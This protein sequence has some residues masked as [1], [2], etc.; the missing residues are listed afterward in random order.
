MTFATSGHAR[1]ARQ[2]WFVEGLRRVLLAR[3]LEE[4]G[5]GEVPR[6]VLHMADPGAPRPFRR[7]AQATF[8]VGMVEGPPPEGP[9]LPAL[10]PLLVRTLS[11]MLLYLTDGAGTPRAYVVTLEQ[12][13]FTIEDADEAAFFAQVYDR[14]YPLA[15]AQLVIN[16]EFHTDLEPE[17]WGGDELSA[18]LAEAGRRLDALNLLPAP[19]PIDEI[20]GPRDMA[21]VRRLFGIG[22]LSY[23]NLSVR[24]DAR[25][26][27][28]SASGVNKGRLQTVG[29]D[30]LM[31]KGY[32]PERNVILLSVPPGVEPRRVSVD[33]IEHWMIY[34]QHPGVGAIIH[35]HAW[36]DG[37]DSTQIQYPCGTLQLAEAVADLVRAAPDPARAVV[38]LRNH[39]MTVTGPTIQD[40]L[41]R[42]E[43][44]LLPRVPMT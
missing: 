2:R 41:A 4:A 20:L 40:I 25:R 43:G 22:G 23:G 26:Y 8:V 32:D 19:F 6:I 5:P 9:I 27:W 31:V 7:R 35:V 16:N 38:G 29:R 28:M 24:K 42:I 39:G 37:I 12:G 33:A 21:H 15:S 17:L 1:T 18:A 13:Y 30:I 14:L 34:T 44:R 11:N 10:Y 3:G 36:M